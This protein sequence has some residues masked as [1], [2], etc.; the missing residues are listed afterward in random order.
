[1]NKLFGLLCFA[2]MLAVSPVSGQRQ[3]IRGEVLWVGG[4]QMPGPGKIATP[5]LG[6]QREVHIYGVTTVDKEGHS[7]PFYTSVKTDLITKFQ[8]KEDGSFKIKLPPGEY[9]VFVK[10]PQGLFA[11]LF[12][13]QGKINP[14]TVQTK[15]FTWVVITVDYE[16]AY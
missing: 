12:D 16:A 2:L 14:V 11:N 6:V 5:K 13:G 1:M 15:Q 10:E 8:T 7:G 9:S 3:G 4:N